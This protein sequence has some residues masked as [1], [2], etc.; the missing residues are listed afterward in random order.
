[1]RYLINNARE[2]NS[3]IDDAI[4]RLRELARQTIGELPPA[5]KPD[6]PPTP[7]LPSNAAIIPELDNTIRS[8][9]DKLNELS[10]LI[11]HLEGAFG[12]DQGPRAGS[13][14]GRG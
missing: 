5:T 12:V 1:M 3:S 14:L 2:H 11:S 6:V 9:M 4:F 8:T 10:L 7:P 13:S